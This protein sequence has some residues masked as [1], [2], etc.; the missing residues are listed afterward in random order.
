M[1]ALTSFDLFNEDGRVHSVR[2]RPSEAASR[3][4]NLLLVL[5]QLN[6]SY[7]LRHSTTQALQ[8]LWCI[9]LFVLE[10]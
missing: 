7:W 9:A 2:D 10:L 6:V 5:S 1:G 8:N 4:E 3:I